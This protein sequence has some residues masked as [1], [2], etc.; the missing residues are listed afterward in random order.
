MNEEFRE[1]QKVEP[2]QVPFKCPVCNGF[3][4]LKYGAVECHACRGLGYVVI[5][6]R[7]DLVLDDLPNN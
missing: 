4:S 1:T 2:Q 5:P 3:G 6:V 7:K